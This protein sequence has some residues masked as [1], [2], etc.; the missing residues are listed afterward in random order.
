MYGTE[1][2]LVQIGDSTIRILK[3]NGRHCTVPFDRL[4]QRDLAYVVQLAKTTIRV[5][6]K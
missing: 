6:Q 1:G 5:A 4:S 3:V 2:R